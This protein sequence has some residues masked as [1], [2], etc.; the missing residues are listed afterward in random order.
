MDNK[1]GLVRLINQGYTIYVATQPMIFED[2][3]I[4]EKLKPHVKFFNCLLAENRNWY[5]EKIT[6]F[7]KRVFGPKAM[8]TD[9]W[10]DHHFGIACGVTLGFLNST[11]EPVSMMRFVRHFEENS[12]HEWTLLVNP[13]YQGKG[14]GLA[15]LSL[16]CE[17]SKN[18]KRISFTTQLDN[19]A[20]VLY[21]H[22][23]NE[24][25]PLE[26]L[27]TGFHHTHP[28]SILAIAKML[29]DSNS[30]MK[31]YRMPPI[32][33]GVLLTK[34]VQLIPGKYLL[35]ANDLVGIKR[36]S[37]N[38]KDGAKYNIIGWYQDWEEKSIEVPITMVEKV[39]GITLAP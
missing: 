19:N 39:K 12:I 27:A 35:L 38:L 37:R 23:T 10:V 22:L 8:P 14:F 16:G 7:N 31:K 6:E 2:L 20:V 34:E 36:I 25:N 4:N 3:T 28:N 32:E 5:N 15:T 33:E 30:L 11:G 1:S 21:L 26:L 17:S 18:K 9:K 24:G 29:K 13:K